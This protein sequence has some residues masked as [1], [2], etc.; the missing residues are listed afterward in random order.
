MSQN[1]GSMVIYISNK[2]FTEPAEKKLAKL[3]KQI[4]K[5]DDLVQQTEERTFSRLAKLSMALSAVVGTANIISQITGQTID[6]SYIVMIQQLITL[7]LSFATFAATQEAMG[8]WAYIPIALGVLGVINQVVGMVN[9][10]RTAAMR[11]M[12][13][14]DKQ[15]NAGLRTL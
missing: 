4:K 9:R 7:K 10:Q 8:N 3:D 5:T 12:E 1:R 11:S 15:L 14:R 2:P 6:T 13:E